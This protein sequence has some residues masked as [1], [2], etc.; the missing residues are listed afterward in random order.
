MRRVAALVQNAQKVVKF[1]QTV[2][3]FELPVGIREQRYDILV[4]DVPERAE[5]LIVIVNWRFEV[6]LN[7]VR[8]LE[9][10]FHEDAVVSDAV[11]HFDLHLG[12]EHVVLGH[13]VEA[14]RELLLDSA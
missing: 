9:G 12:E 4:E 5:V 1:L 14:L 11:V 7:V 13:A 6:F 10:L 2:P 8:S 3:Y